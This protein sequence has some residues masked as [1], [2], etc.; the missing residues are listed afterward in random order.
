MTPP[1]RSL[2]TVAVTA[3][4]DED[5]DPTTRE[6][7]A[8]LLRAHE[9]GDTEATATLADAFSTIL[10]L[11]AAGLRGRPGAGP[12]RMNRVVVI[13]AAAGL[14]AYL[15]DKL[16]AG[17][18]VVIGYDAH[19][20][21]DA[22]ARD[23]ASVITGAGGRALLFE[24]HCPTPV[25]AFALRRLGADA[26]VMATTSRRPPRDGGGCED[27][28]DANGCDD[29]SNWAV[30]LGG[31]VV[32]GPGRGARIV[33]PHDAEIAERIAAVGSL[34]GVPMPD[35]GWEGLG[36]EVVEEYTD[37]A[38]RA[39]RMRAAA[40]LRVV[41]AAMRGEGGR[42]CRDALS[43]VGLD[44]VVVPEQFDPDPDSPAVVLSAPEESGRL[45]PAL[46]LARQVDADLVIAIGPD[47]GRCCAA[48]PDKHVT[49]GWRRLTGDEVGTVLGEQAAELAAFTGTGILAS[50]IVSS[51]M[52]RRIAQA[53]GLGHRNALTGFR[54][55]SRVP[56]LVFGYEEA[57][58][59]CVD[60]ASVR[61]GDGI[62]AAVRLTVL[63]SVLK[64]QG[65]SI[66]DLLERLAREHGLHATRPLRVRVEDPSLIPGTMDR[67][68]AGGVPASLAGSPVV[69][70][71]DLMDGASDG[72]G[73]SLPP[74]DGLIIKTAADDRVVV[75][76]SGAEPALTC[77]CEVVVPVAVEDPVEVARRTAADRLELMTTDLHGVLGI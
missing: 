7:L 30:Y 18:A 19:H 38:A 25:L 5:P 14:A 33:P 75:L 12:G 63:A 10:R 53:H 20:G 52:L 71:F 49:G 66:A 47:A 46:A 68:R 74:A 9:N 28:A 76:P 37:S 72:N 77:Y 34:D 65:R 8:A 55:I 54:W 29:L 44:V 13:R 2:D 67:L 1:D 45:D 41:L 73:G 62:S 11:G 50:S 36:A 22:L 69:D 23:T 56:G 39:A 58:G 51:R 27:R 21:S 24:S 60:P 57:L 61:D 31:R 48:I 35:S 70:V 6:E 15:R 16:G 59:Y 32:T 17:F 43:R 40:P 4:I 3:W 26:A 64:Q 42:I